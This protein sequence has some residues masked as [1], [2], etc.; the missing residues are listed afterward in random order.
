[1]PEVGCA[2]TALQLHAGKR[3]GARAGDGGHGFRRVLREPRRGSRE[4]AVRTLLGISTR[5]SV[6]HTARVPGLLR[7]AQA[8]KDRHLPLFPA[9]TQHRDSGGGGEVNS[10]CGG[11]C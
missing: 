1:M 9:A 7:P 3:A 6:R 4:D 10:S 2:G 5:P 8:S 11:L